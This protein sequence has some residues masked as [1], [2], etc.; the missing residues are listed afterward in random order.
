MWFDTMG[1]IY[2]GSTITCSLSFLL[3]PRSFSPLPQDTLRARVILLSFTISLFRTVSLNS[4]ITELLHYSN[5]FLIGR[6]IVPQD[7]KLL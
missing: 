7:R 4:A 1:G 5:T 2:L 6:R 3:F